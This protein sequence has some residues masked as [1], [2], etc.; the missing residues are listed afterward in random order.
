MLRNA[1]PAITQIP[2]GDGDFVIVLEYPLP[3]S[4]F[5]F[6]LFFSFH[7][8]WFGEEQLALWEFFQL[9]GAITC[10][11]R[12]TGLSVEDFSFVLNWREAH[13]CFYFS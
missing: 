2:I 1:L 5:L 12:L 6:F 3:I 9:E 8:S 11:H 10:M 13:F 7:T 4:Y